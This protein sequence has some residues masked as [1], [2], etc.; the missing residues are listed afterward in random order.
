MMRIIIPIV[1]LVIGLGVMSTL[2]G[3]AG[4]EERIEVPPIE[5]SVKVHR[6]Q[7][8]AQTAEVSSS[9]T[10]QPAQQ[11]SIIPQVSGAIVAIA[12][13]LQAGRRFKKGELIAQ[14]DRTDYQLIVE[15]ER[16]RVE[17]A[18]LNL[19]IEEERQQGAQREWALLGK[20]G[21]APE[22]ASRKPQLALAKI[23]LQSAQASLQRA[24]V[25]LGRTAIKAP[26]NSIVQQEQLEVGQVVGADAPVAS[27]VG[28]DQYWIRV[29]VPTARLLD[30][31]IPDVNADKGSAVQVV[32]SPS[33]RHSDERTGRVLRLEGA[34]DP[35]A[36]TANLLI[37]IDDPLEGDGLPLMIGAYVNV[38]ILGKQI[39][40]GYKIPAVA[41]LDGTYVLVADAEDKLARKDVAVGWASGENI[42]L[43]DGVAEND[44]VITTPI[45]YP[46]YGSPLVIVEEK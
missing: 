46:V 33:E 4:V 17:Q 21:E 19:Q 41:L 2:I 36:R 39:E 23:N 25:A 13:G 24:E 15:Q 26:F 42:V 44:R 38:M 43:V 12:D 6:V 14:I 29:S 16:A 22:L 10:V 20:E 27:L 35:Q 8:Q 34:L 31:D 37:G 1:I 18:E 3:S 5:I 30:I 7:G 32:Y 40:R 45:S 11:V 28:T 9:G